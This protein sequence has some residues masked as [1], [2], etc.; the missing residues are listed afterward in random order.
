MG[1]PALAAAQR[2]NGQPRLPFVVDG[3]TVG[4][5]PCAALGALSAWPQWLELTP[6]RVTLTAA[7][8]DAALATINGALRKQGWVRAWRDELFA[9]FDPAGDATGDTT[10]DISARRPLARTERAASRFWGTLTLGAHANGYLMTGPGGRPTHLWVA[11]RSFTKATDP[12]LRDNLVGGGVP[13]GQA[14][15]EALV[16]EGWE[17]A[18]LTAPQMAP[19]RPGRVLRLHRDIPEGLQLEDLHTFDLALPAGLVPCNQDGEVAGFECLPV[20]DALALAASGAMT[21]DAELVTLDFALRHR[22]L[23]ANEARRL[24]LRFSPLL[25]GRPSR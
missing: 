15:L 6:G 7:D 12:G 24:S 18:G 3:C 23:P 9:I 14:P 10:S 11:Q 19:A 22:L 8:R 1:W 13:H 4:S 20:A 25:A 2:R 17:E 5:V 16:R 21:V